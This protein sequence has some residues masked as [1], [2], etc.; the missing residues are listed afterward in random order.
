MVHEGGGYLVVF[1]C[2][3]ERQTVMSLPRFPASIQTSQNSMP[4]RMKNDA[5]GKYKQKWTGL[6]C[7]ALFGRSI[8]IYMVESKTAYLLATTC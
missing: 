2:V 4:G 8:V 3:R 1:E 5:Q 6:S 7:Q